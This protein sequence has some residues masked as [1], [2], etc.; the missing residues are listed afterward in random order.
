[1][2]VK[3]AR[4]VG[5]K[6]FCDACGYESVRW[7]GRCPGCN[8]FDSMVEAPLDMTEDDPAGAS[9]PATRLA[10]QEIPSTGQQRTPTGSAEVD[11]VLGGGLVPASVTLLGGEPG[12]GKSTLL[13]STC[14]RVAASGGRCVY[15]SAEE[16]ASQLK[17]RADRISANGLPSEFYVCE[18]GDLP[19][20]LKVAGDAALVV[21]D[22][23]Q[24]VRVPTIRSISGSVLQIRE[25]VFRIL[26][27]A[28]RGKS[29][30]AYVLV[31]HITKGGELAGPKVL[32]HMV[33]T[34]L[35]FEGD[36]RL[37]LRFLR[38]QKNRFGSTEEIGV[39]EMTG[40][41]L[42]EV[43]DPGALFRSAGDSALA[44]VAVSALVEGSR[45]FLVEIQS[46]TQEV[47][48]AMP[49]RV[50]TGIDPRRLLLIL[51]VLEKRVGLRL[52]TSDVFASAV[53]G[54]VAREPAADLAVAM[55]I[56]S[57]VRSSPLLARTAFVGEVTLTGELREP[58]NVDRRIAE[59]AR[60]GFQ[61]IVLPAPSGRNRVPRPPAGRQID[62]VYSKSIM[63]CK[64]KYLS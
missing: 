51:A 41:G 32:E 55:A 12:I 57:A 10:L 46:L 58:P 29:A 18:S 52:G 7:M 14:L 40:E 22:S 39:F 8:A 44:G 30:P 34:V 56:A 9:S 5:P 4:S 47:N 45:A 19:S 25:C 50:A 26:E 17:M 2:T 63:E 33:D 27:S 21:V 53:G 11:R 54:F 62:I 37:G 35:S 36:R 61:E 6:F 31:G 20:A 48:L 59:S 13:L 43:P 49:R 64:A 60:L 16:S 28:K 24:T 38:A 42:A 15:I 23:I 3:K 1:M